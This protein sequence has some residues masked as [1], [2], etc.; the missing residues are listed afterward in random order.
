MDG[1][2]VERQGPRILV[3]VVFGVV[4]QR[5]AQK[6]EHGI[7]APQPE[8]S[9]EG[10]FPSDVSRADIEGHIVGVPFLRVVDQPARS[11]GGACWGHSW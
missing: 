5:S 3:D 4:S 7:E 1:I 11:S 9:L 10:V 6:V 2:F 8:I